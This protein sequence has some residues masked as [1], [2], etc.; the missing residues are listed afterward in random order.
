MLFRNRNQMV[1]TL[2]PGSMLQ[3]YVYLCVC[4]FMCIHSTS[5][6]QQAFLCSVLNWGPRSFL[7]S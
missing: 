7:S 6:Q 4:V 1:A 3:P 5:R 2:H